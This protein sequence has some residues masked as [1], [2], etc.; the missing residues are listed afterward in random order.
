MIAFSIRYEFMFV[1]YEVSRID[2]FHD[3]FINA[4]F[5][6]LRKKIERDTG[7]I[8]SISIVK[9]STQTIRAI[10]LLNSNNAK[11]R[12]LHFDSMI[13]KMCNGIPRKSHTI[14]GVSAPA[15][16]NAPSRY[17]S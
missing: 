12:Q 13:R 5:S 6:P 1:V 7:A 15:I 17:R 9:P 3:Q 16:I 8:Q 10:R 11:E 2:L 14:I 4:Q